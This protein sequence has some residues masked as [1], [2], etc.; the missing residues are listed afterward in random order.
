MK[1]YMVMV[2]ES[3]AVEIEA[4]YMENAGGVLYF[5]RGG[6]T[7]ASATPANSARRR[8]VISGSPGSRLIRL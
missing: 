4:E 6:Q 3:K 2:T 7:V 1:K 8:C 5:T